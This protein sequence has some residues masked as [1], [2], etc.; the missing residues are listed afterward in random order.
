MKAVFRKHKKTRNADV[1]KEASRMWYVWEEEGSVIYL[2]SA[3]LLLDKEALRNVQCLSDFNNHD[4][5]IPR[6]KKVVKPWKGE[7]HSVPDPCKATRGICQ[8]A[9]SQL[10]CSGRRM[11]EISKIMWNVPYHVHR[12]A[13]QSCSHHVAVQITSKPKVSCVKNNLGQ[14]KERSFSNF[15]SLEITCLWLK[16]ATI[17]SGIE[18]RQV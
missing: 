17:N 3:V 4:L 15:Y 7:L 13:T 1:L 14:W 9:S 12:G 8:P 2:A 5:Q 11:F 18:K 16:S 10:F 6:E